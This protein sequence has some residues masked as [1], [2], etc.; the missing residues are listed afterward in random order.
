MDHKVTILPDVGG[1]ANNLDDV[2]IKCDTFV[3]F[4]FLLLM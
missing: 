4:F 1:V 3:N 2:D